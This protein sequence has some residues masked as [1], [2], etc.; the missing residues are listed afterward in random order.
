MI[1]VSVNAWREVRRRP[2]NPEEI[3]SVAEHQEDPTEEA[4]VKVLGHWR[5]GVEAGI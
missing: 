1:R 2:A 4:A 3:K 5:N